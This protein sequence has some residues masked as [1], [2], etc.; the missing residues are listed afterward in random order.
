MKYQGSPEGWRDTHGQG[1]RSLMETA[2]GMMRLCFT[3]CQ[4]SR[5]KA[6][7]EREL[8]VKVLT[9]NIGRLYYFECAGRL[10]FAQGREK[11]YV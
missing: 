1:R 2:F 8:L 7:Q 10:L 5:G 4:N 3:G 9:Y 11:Q 6:Q